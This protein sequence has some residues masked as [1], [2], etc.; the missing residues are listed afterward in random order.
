MKNGFVFGMNEVKIPENTEE[1]L[2]LW[3]TE[4]IYLRNQELLQKIYQYLQSAVKVNFYFVLEYVRYGNDEGG[5]GLYWQNGGKETLVLSIRYQI[6][7]LNKYTDFQCLFTYG[8]VGILDFLYSKLLYHPSIPVGRMNIRPNIYIEDEVWKRIRSIRSAYKRFPSALAVQNPVMYP[9]QCILLDLHEENQFVL[10]QM[11]AYPKDFWNKYAIYSI[12]QETA[13]FAMNTEKADFEI[14]N[15]EDLL[16][17]RRMFEF[18]SPAKE[19]L[20]F[21]ARKQLASY[22]RKLEKEKR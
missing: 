2:E 7:K 13:A 15:M 10:K 3:N 1:M 20:D 5:F 9:A 17:G 8:L 19:D 16:N 21:Y 6:S 18:R 4:E 11:K 14:H 22:K 12:R